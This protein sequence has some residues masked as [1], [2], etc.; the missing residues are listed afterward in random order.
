[1]ICTSCG[2]LASDGARVCADTSC[3]STRLRSV[4]RLNQRGTD[5]VKGCLVCGAR[6]EGAVRRFETGPDASGAVIATSLYQRLP[7]STLLEDR[8]RPGEGRKLLMFSDSRQSAAY[9]AP[10]LE[11]SYARV[12]RR[13]L[14]AQ[15]LE[16]AATEGMPVGVQDLVFAA[17][18]HADA[19][20]H[21][22]PRM[23]AQ[24]QMRE[25][26][27]WVMAE[28]LALDDRISL[29]G[30]GLVRITMDRDPSWV[31]PA[32]LVSAGLSEDEA[33][34][35]VE[36]L[37]RTLRQQ[38]AVTMPED[39]PPND[40]IFAPRLGPI[41]ARLE[42]PAPDPQGPVVAPGPGHQ[43]AHRL[44][45]QGSRGARLFRRPACGAGGRLAV[46]HDRCR[47]RLAEE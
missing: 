45:D 25:V 15:G 46:P 29:E 17:R 2:T 42:G 31:A 12:Q 20:R 19:V 23:T 22:K 18:K 21:F 33:W 27:P 13:R 8:N 34:D 10:Y 32:P 47:R 38:G 3:G 43:P 4:R 11:D 40:E 36:E 7:A 9:F 6:G 41:Y 16:S 14:I 28:A 26:A 1:M 5:E 37:V 30:L 44:H 35:F 39:V 24:Q